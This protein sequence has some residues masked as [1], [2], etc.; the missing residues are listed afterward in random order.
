MQPNTELNN[1][2]KIIELL[3]QSKR[4]S[5]RQGVVSVFSLF[6]QHVLSEQ[7]DIE[8]KMNKIL[9]SNFH[10]F[11]EH[12]LLYHQ[13]SPSVENYWKNVGSYLRIAIDDVKQE[14]D[15]EEDADQMKLL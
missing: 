8:E 5:F 11:A 7:N 1:N 6:P 4:D 10:R 2:S 13:L 12:G 3:Q 15:D 9:E 14:I